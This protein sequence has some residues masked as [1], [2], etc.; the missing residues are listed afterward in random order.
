MLHR[1]NTSYTQPMVLAGGRQKNISS[2]AAEAGKCD[3]KESYLLPNIE[4]LTVY[5]I[6]LRLSE[7]NTEFA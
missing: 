6:S 1:T 4:Q 5:T 2:I 7:S 3:R